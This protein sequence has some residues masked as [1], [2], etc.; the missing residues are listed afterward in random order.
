MKLTGFIADGEDSFVAMNLDG[1]W[2]P[3]VC[4][5]HKQNNVNFLRKKMQ[6]AATLTRKTIR[7]FE[8]SQAVEIDVYEP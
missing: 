8:F 7:E 3:A 5:T 6:E 2:Y 4:A 1:T